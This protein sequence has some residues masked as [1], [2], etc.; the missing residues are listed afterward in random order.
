MNKGG[1]KRE[2]EGGKGKRKEWARGREEN[3]KA[4][5]K[6]MKVKKEERE[7]EKDRGNLIKHIE[8]TYFDKPCGLALSKLCC[9][10]LLNS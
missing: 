4:G 5:K 3:W 7:G 2:Q 8:K 1:E 9:I 6:G 10:T